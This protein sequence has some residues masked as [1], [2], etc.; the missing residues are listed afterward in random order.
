MAEEKWIYSPSGIGYNWQFKP[1]T[2]QERFARNAN[3]ISNVL[4]TKWDDAGQLKADLMESAEY[5]AGQA[6]LKRITPL[7]CPESDF[8]YL[9]DL[10]KQQIWLPPVDSSGNYGTQTRDDETGWWSG[11]K[12][13]YLATFVNLP[14]QVKEDEEVKT[15]TLPEL[16]RYCTIHPQ[17]VVQNRVVTSKQFVIDGGADNGKGVNE[18]AAVPEVQTRFLVKQWLWPLA[19]VNWDAIADHSGKVNSSSFVIRGV[20]HPAE[21]LLYE[22][23]G[24]QPEEYT[25]PDGKKYVDLTHS[26]LRHPVNWNKTL[27]NGSYEYIKLRDS[28]PAVR[29]FLTAGFVLPFKPL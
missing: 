25:G 15:L 28:S 17:P 22:G 1:E 11:H 26:L 29:R 19:A 9:A 8:L 27:W 16:N 21:S 24:A 2:Y 18:S 6:W 3:Q 4:V 5:V 13:S 12:L 14:Y 10:T 7:V 20:T 23:L